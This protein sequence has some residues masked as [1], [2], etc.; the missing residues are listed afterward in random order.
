MNYN[1]ADNCATA[2][3]TLSVTSNEPINGTGDGD[4]SP[5][6]EI[7]NNHSVKLRAERSG[8][9]NGRIYTITIKAVDGCN[10]SS[11]KV[12]TV[13]V[14]QN[15]SVTANK[16]ANSL[17]AGKTKLEIID[18]VEVIQL[19][20]TPN[21]SSKHF[22]IHIK[23]NNTKDRLTMQVFDILGRRVELRNNLQ[24]GTNIRVGDKYKQGAYFIRIMQGNEYKVIKL[25]KLSD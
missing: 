22:N 4:A 20:A 9:G 25:I 17:E 5:D 6:W 8:S 23:S 2:T 3:T 18:I 12:V 14:N 13:V 11:T 15:N 7:V 10:N 19:V 16:P 24:T 21:P 1:V